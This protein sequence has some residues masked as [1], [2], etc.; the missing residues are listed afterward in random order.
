[1]FFG[2]LGELYTVVCSQTDAILV[3]TGGGDNKAFMWKIGQGDWA[4]E[5][6]GHQDSVSSLS[7]SADG[8]FLASG[9]L[10][11]VV[12]IWDATDG[13]LHRTLEGPSGAIEW[14]KWH[15][16]KHFLLAGSEDSLCWIWNVDGD[17]R[18]RVFAGHGSSVTC[19][20][21]T[22]DGQRICTCSDDATMRIWDART[23]NIIHVV[24]GHPYHTEGITSLTINSDSTLALTGSSDGSVHVVNIATGKVVSSLTSHS[25]SVE[26]A[27]FEPSS[28][29]DNW[30][31]ATGALD[32]KLVIWDQQS[33]S[34]RCICEHEEGVACLVWLG[35]GRYVATG[36]LDGMVRIWDGLSGNC[37]R[38]LHGHS[39]AIQGLGVSGNGDFLVS[40]SIDG[41]ARAFEVAEFR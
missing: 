1:F 6:N 21:F 24:K 17:G 5:L 25:D 33:T 36:C 30:R 29:G 40:V 16:V 8:R 26:C 37:L 4:L 28:R 18:L 27:A 13:H 19:G 7:F 9:S 10:D 20:D 41:T 35:R 14:V 22:P 15:P 32:K 3:A 12:K 31:V 34:P 38:E 39:D 11:G 2:H 23:A